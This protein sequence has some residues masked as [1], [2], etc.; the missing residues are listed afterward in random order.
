VT[1]ELFGTSTNGKSLFSPNDTIGAFA[2]SVD[3]SFD[4]AYKGSKNSLQSFRGYGAVCNFTSSF[5]RFIG[6]PVMNANTNLRIYFDSSGSLGTETLAS[7]NS[8]NDDPQYI[9]ALL[10]PYYNNDVALY[11]DKVKV[12]SELNERTLYMLNNSTNTPTSG[13]III[14]V[15]Q[16]EAQDTSNDGNTWGYTTNIDTF[17]QNATRLSQY[18][19]DLATFRGRLTTFYNNNPDY[20]RGVVFQVATAGYTAFKPF[21]QAVENGT[22]QYSGI[23]GLS[24]KPEVIYKYDVVSKSTPRYYTDLISAALNS[25][26]IQT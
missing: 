1:V 8:A 7:L 22:G 4:P 24:D 6:S 14:M 16:D 21:L 23:N 5:V 11:G 9:R 2:K 26:N 3:A 17:D 25:L 13:N 20:Y 19:T 18:D 12:T 15:F 10:L